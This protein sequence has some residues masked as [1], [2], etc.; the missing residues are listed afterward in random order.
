MRKDLHQTAHKRSCDTEVQDLRQGERT[1]GKPVDMEDPKVSVRAPTGAAQ[2]ETVESDTKIDTKTRTNRPTETYMQNVKSDSPEEQ[3]GGRAQAG[4][5]RNCGQKPGNTVRLLEYQAARG[6]ARV[7]TVPIGLGLVP[8]RPQHVAVF[9]VDRPRRPTVRQ[10]DVAVRTWVPAHSLL[11]G[12]FRSLLRLVGDV[13]QQPRK[14]RQ[15][16]AVFV[17]HCNTRV[18]GVH[19]RAEG[20]V[21]DALQDGAA[22]KLGALI[23]C[24]LGHLLDDRH[25]CDGDPLRLVG[26][27][28]DHL[29]PNGIKL[30]S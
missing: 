21:Q 10:L 30:V 5:R 3:V 1:Q 9:G 14:G 15:R 4:H 17:V 29:N 22:P 19:N 11:E 26:D 20:H 28:V 25:V 24:R 16:L 12:K 8:Q 23:C 6:P 18:T 13:Q 27:D 7:A 2:H